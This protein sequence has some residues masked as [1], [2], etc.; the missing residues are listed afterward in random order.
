MSS[1]PKLIATSKPQIQASQS[2]ILLVAENLSYIKI[3]TWYSLGDTISGLVK[4]RL[5][6]NQ[7]DH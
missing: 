2:A 4:I 1:I 7:F 3:G 5:P 6:I